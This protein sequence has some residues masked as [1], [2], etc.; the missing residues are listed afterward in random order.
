M[1][2]YRKQATGSDLTPNIQISEDT[3]D[4]TA[5]VPPHSHLS[6][7]RWHPLAVIAVTVTATLLVLGAAFS[8]AAR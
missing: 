3:G 7:P 4:D 6:D 2:L 5:Y 8:I 1:T